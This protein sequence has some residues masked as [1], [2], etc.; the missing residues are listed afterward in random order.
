MGA[1]IIFGGKPAYKIRH[2]GALINV[3]IWWDDE[4][5]TLTTRAQWLWFYRVTHGGAR[6]PFDPYAA[7]E[8]SSDASVFDVLFAATELDQTRFGEVL[9]HRPRRRRTPFTKPLRSQIYERDGYRCKHCGATENL[10]IDHIHPFSLGGLE[11][12]ANLQT[13]C[14]SCNSRKGARVQGAHSIHQA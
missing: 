6:T 10:S 11:D 4:F 12:A 2:D 3:N 9:E 8:S 13:L 5:R 7:A 14:R 1:P